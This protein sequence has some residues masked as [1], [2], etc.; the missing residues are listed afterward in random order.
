MAIIAITSKIC[1]IPGALY[2]KKPIAQAIIRIT[3]MI[4]NKFPM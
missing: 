3:A 1:M 2:P 4:Y